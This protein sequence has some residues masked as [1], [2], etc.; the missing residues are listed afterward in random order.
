MN[1][2]SG[3]CACDLYLPWCM[4]PSKGGV[5]LSVWGVLLRI[6][7]ACI[8]LCDHKHPSFKS[9]FLPSLSQKATEKPPFTSPSP[10]GGLCPA[11]AWSPCCGGVS[12][13]HPKSPSRSVGHSGVQGS[14]RSWLVL[15]PATA[16]RQN[17]LASPQGSFSP[18]F[19]WLPLLQHG[20]MTCTSFQRWVFLLPCWMC[21]STQ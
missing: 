2:L 10:R 6:A 13:A 15:I 9:H 8:F 12:S 5:C 1:G 16:S 20:L 21:I 3:V 11:M 14:F 7:P 18:L 19:P 17:L 4:E